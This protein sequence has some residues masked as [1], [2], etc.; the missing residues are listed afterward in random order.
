M[1]KKTRAMGANYL[2]SYLTQQH[3]SVIQLK[4]THL[5]NINNNTFELHLDLR[6]NMIDMVLI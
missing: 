2:R 5:I 3:I 6:E 1:K 4:W